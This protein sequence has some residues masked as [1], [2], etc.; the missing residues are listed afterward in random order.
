MLRFAHYNSFLSGINHHVAFA[1]IRAV[2]PINNDILPLN[3]VVYLVGTIFIQ[4]GPGYRPSMINAIHL[5]TVGGDPSTA[6]YR[7]PIPNVPASYIEAV[8]TVSC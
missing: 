1:D 7:H 2:G 6:G 8:G 5:H 3:S 4:T